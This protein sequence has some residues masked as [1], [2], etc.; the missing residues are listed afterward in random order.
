MSEARSNGSSGMPAEKV[1]LVYEESVEGQRNGEALDVREFAL[2]G[3]QRCYHLP[4]FI[5][6]L[7]AYMDKL[8]SLYQKQE[9]SLEDG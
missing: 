8:G 1:A 7:V 5:D 2:H 9:S 6:A 4:L 3:L